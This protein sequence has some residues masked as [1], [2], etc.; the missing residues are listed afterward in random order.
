[1]IV[2]PVA[3]SDR[4]A[5]LVAG[6][7]EQLRR[8][9]GDLD[10]VIT[11][12]EGDARRAARHAAEYGYERVFVAGGDGTLNEALNGVCDVSGALSQVSF[13]I[14]PI[15]TGNDF[16]AILG[17]PPDLEAALAAFAAGHV[18]LVDVGRL[19]GEHFVNVSAG[20]FIAEVSDAVTPQMKTIAGRLAYLLG[21]AQTLLTHD[22]QL[23]SGRRR[24][25]DCP[26]CHT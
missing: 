21:G 14:V 7:N 3:G 6:L 20:G 25:A 4:G 23:A 17:I 9:F 16:A 12:A 2:N 8:H 5:D 22:P 19:N 10:I 26:G 11:T 13:G 18:Q 24:P 1:L 15:G